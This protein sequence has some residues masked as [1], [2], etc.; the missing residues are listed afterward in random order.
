MMPSS[1]G[2]HRIC[3]CVCVCVFVIS[4]L[5]ECHDRSNPPRA[6]HGLAEEKERRRPRNTDAHTNNA[7]PDDAS[8][9]AS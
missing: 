1:F 8:R 9:I 5:T 7:R 4:M 3:V 2:F 6:E